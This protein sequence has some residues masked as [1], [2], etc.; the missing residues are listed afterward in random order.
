MQM[1]TFYQVA[2]ALA[3]MTGLAA[4]QP[5]PP[6]QPK[7]EAK[8]TNAKPAEPAAGGMPEMKAPAEVAAMAKA[9]AGTWRCKGQGMD[10][11]AMKMADMNATMKMKSALSGWWIQGSF[12][13]KMGKETFAFE[14]F[15]TF[16]PS[17]KKW[18]RVMVDNSGGWMTGESAGAKDGKVDWEMAAH[19]PMGGGMF[20]DHEDMSDPKVGVKMWGE[21]SPDNGKTWAKV[22]EMACKK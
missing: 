5:A 7:T 13:S 6:A 16:D 19:G 21:F 22:Y 1:K 8:T 20:R 11:K 12:E 14:T 9:T 3:A 18:K 15:T 17:S 10:M 4:A 2:I